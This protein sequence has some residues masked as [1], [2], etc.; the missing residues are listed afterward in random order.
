LHLRTMLKSALR[1][2]PRGRQHT[3]AWAVEGHSEYND[4]AWLLLSPLRYGPQNIRSVWPYD[5][6]DH[7]G[8]LVLSGASI[9]PFNYDDGN[10]VG[11]EVVV[12]DREAFIN[13]LGR[14]I[15]T[16]FRCS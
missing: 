2:T 4:R 1:L 13:S 9:K 8:L 7:L 6:I 11:F 3:V 14:T 16:L 5:H 12:S 10:C 15:D